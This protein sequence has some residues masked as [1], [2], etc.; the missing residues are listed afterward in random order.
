VVNAHHKEVADVYI[1]DGVV[2]S[3]RPNIKVSDNLKRM[4]V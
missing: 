4:L 1:E 2:L 3:V